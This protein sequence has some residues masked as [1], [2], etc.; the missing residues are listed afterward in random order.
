MASR[1]PRTVMYRR[2]REHKTSYPKRLKL[3]L[4]GKKRIV[5]RLT[6]SRVIAQLVEFTP[7]GDKI[8]AGVDSFALRKY[9]WKYSCKNIPAAYLTGFLLGRK[10]KD[11]KFKDTSVLDTGLNYPQHKGRI[12]AFLKGALDAGISVPHGETDL[13]P[14]EKKIEGQHVQEYGE[15]I[16]GNKDVYERQFAQYLKSNSAPENMAAAFMQVKQKITGQTK[17]E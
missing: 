8:L 4:S 6:N 13:F 7:K 10:A 9:G 17:N 15:K 2:K 12:Y 11:K 14:E 1:K 16:K 5:V 3:L